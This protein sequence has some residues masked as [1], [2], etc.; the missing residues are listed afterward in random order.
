MTDSLQFKG[1][2]FCV[3]VFLAVCLIAPWTTLTAQAQTFTVLYTFKG[4]R[5]GAYPSGTLVRDAQGNLYGT[6]YWGGGYSYQGTAFKLD[7]RGH[8]TVL[9]RFVAGYGANPESGLIQGKTGKF[10]GTT[11][12]GGAH[13]KGS[14]FEIDK[15]GHERVLHS[16]QFNQGITL[17]AGVVQ[18][19]VGNFYGTADLGGI[20]GCDG[21]NGD[22]CGTVYRVSKAGETQALY[23]FTGGVDGAFPAATLVRDKVGNLYGAAGFGGD[24]TYCPI[25]C[26][27]LFKLTSA[28]KLTVLYTF[29]GTSSDGSAPEA[30]MILDDAGNLYGTTAYGGTAGFGI[31][32]KLDTVGTLTVLHNFLGPPDDGA[33]PWEPALTRDTDGNLYGVT[34]SGGVQ[35]DGTVFALHPDGTETLLH[36]FTGSGG[37]G[38][39]P[40]GVLVLDEA[41]NLYGTADGGNTTEC[42]GGCG[43]VFKIQ[44]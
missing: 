26:G 3:I 44:P 34:L 41:G 2:L 16:F 20:P 1:W 37:D 18:D 8:E 10:Y 9:Y 25:G 17:D 24:A 38:V 35:N 15:S 36:Q 32:F 40:N 6:T 31:V 42:S 5:D 39:R 22:G 11:V 7:P 23:K 43:I 30:G 4:G 12:K 33:Y 19:E 21:R 29:T 13:R 14:L 28:G 27:T